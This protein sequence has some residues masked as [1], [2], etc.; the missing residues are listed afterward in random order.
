MDNNRLSSDVSPTRYWIKIEPRY[1][2]GTFSGRVAIALDVKKPV[3]EV[4]LNALALKVKHG[5]VYVENKSGA[6]MYGIIH[7]DNANERLIICFSGLLGTGKWRLHLK[8]QGRLDGRLNGFYTS[9][10]KDGAGKEQIIGS[11]QFEPTDAR[12]AFPCFDEPSFKA[13]YNLTLVISKDQTAIS[14]SPVVKET[15]LP[16]G[17]KEVVFAETI[18][19]STYLV[20]WVIG[21]LEATEP[22]NVN[23]TDIR[24]Y[25]VP[26][27]SHLTRFALKAA[28]FVLARYEKYF[29]IKYPS[30]KLDMIAIPN[31]AFGGMENFGCITYRE[32]ALLVD[33]KTASLAELARVGEVVHHEIAHMWFGDYVTMSW[34]NGLWLNEA[35]ATFMSNKSLDEWKPEWHVWNRFCSADR[36]NALKTDGLASTRPIEALVA[37]ASQALAMVDVITYRKGCS[38]MRMLEQYLGA[39]IFRQ[40]IAHYM[41]QH[42]LGSTETSDLWDALELIA[43]KPVR[44]MMEGW[45]FRP[46]YPLI[47]VEASE[48]PGAITLSQRCFKYLAEAV[49]ND[50]IWLVPITI[51]AKTRDGIIETTIELNQRQ[52]N[53][54]IGEG[55]EWIVVNAGSYGFYRTRYSASLASKL[56][57][58]VQEIL[59]PIERF[60]FVNDTWAC[61]QAGL[62]SS[63]EYIE[64]IQMFALEKDPNVWSIIID[65]LTT[66]YSVLP[67]SLKKALS[68]D[69]CELARPILDEL[70][71]DEKSSD[72]SEIKRLRG[73]LVNFLGTVGGDV[74]VQNIVRAMYV[75]YKADRAA[76]AVD[77]VPAMI[78][79]VAYTGSTSE[80][81]E[82][83]LAYHAA[84]T[85]QE[86]QRSLFALASFNDTQLLEETLAATI[87]DEVRSQDAPGL[88]AYLMQNQNIAARTWQFVKDHFDEMLTRFPEIGFTRVFSGIVALST[89]ELEEDVRMTLSSRQIKGGEKAIPQYLELLR[90][91]VAFRK[92]ESQFLESV[93][94]AKMLA[95][96]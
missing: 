20:A 89:P 77:V 5:S 28:A 80:Y 57:K 11:T 71:F 78:S 90:I 32:T 81:N 66:I 54:Y 68:Q 60:N 13:K 7:W 83:K 48:I 19:M 12:R 59:S 2:S 33:E 4:V 29:E 3:S 22:I 45:I 62:V 58:N 49:D 53:I 85:P 41:K 15:V 95:K 75:R 10:Y 72:S 40:G 67:E 34:W 25:H 61:V 88:V 50:Q 43:K 64:L 92:R 76:I 23:G 93:Y 46:G 21:N 94:Q 70:G 24:I 55:L 31:F 86:Q 82:F 52:K 74:E 35:F 73:S 6:R 37:S 39:E 47:T 87:T 9:T 14:N 51:R 63:S 44:Q 38:V 16:S 26:G 42:A 96:K 56:V 18:S 79:V 36:A 84:L 17:K 30:T 27:K 69:I 1:D 8:Y 65:S 91:A